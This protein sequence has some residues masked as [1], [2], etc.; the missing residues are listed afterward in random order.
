MDIVYNWVSSLAVFVAGFAIFYAVG[1]FFMR[2]LYTFLVDDARGTTEGKGLATYCEERNVLL[3]Y[4][5][6]RPGS[7]VLGALIGALSF[8]LGASMLTA[9]SLGCCAFLVSG[10]LIPRLLASGRNAV[11]RLAQ[12]IRR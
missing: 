10:A 7:T 6:T 11:L 1:Q 12:R 5:W 9:I 3:H 2:G 8:R 4:V